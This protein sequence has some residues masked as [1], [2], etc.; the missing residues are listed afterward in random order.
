MPIKEVCSEHRLFF[1][2]S[3]PRIM[4]LCNCSHPLLRYWE[5]CPCVVITVAGLHAR[6]RGLLLTAC[7]HVRA[8]AGAVPGAR[9][10]VAGRAAAAQLHGVLRDVPRLPHAGAAAGGA[11]RS[12]R[13]APLPPHPGPPPRRPPPVRACLGSYMS[14]APFLWGIM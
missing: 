10:G 8:G 3:Y 6:M 2:C 13:R 4:A 12:L 11:G 14:Y 5:V 1:C 7:H 9:A